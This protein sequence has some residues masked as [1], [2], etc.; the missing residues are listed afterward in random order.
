[1]M[2]PS[3][4]SVEC[5]ITQIFEGILGDTLFLTLIRRIIHLPIIMFFLKLERSDPT[6]LFLFHSHQG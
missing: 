6:N 4:K 5:C 1:M 2:K 3:G